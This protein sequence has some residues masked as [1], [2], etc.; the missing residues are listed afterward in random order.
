MSGYVDIDGLKLMCGSPSLEDCAQ[1]EIRQ[2]RQE[3]LALRRLAAISS[4]IPN[5]IA[6]VRRAQAA[7]EAAERGEWDKAGLVFEERSEP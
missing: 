5:V 7:L 4:D 1:M 6:V 3:L 2:C